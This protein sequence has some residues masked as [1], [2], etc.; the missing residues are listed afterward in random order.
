MLALAVQVGLGQNR[1]LGFYKSTFALIRVACSLLSA[2][3]TFGWW[4]HTFAYAQP[5]QLTI[6]RVVN[7]MHLTVTE[8]ANTYSLFCARPSDYNGSI[9]K[10]INYTK[11]LIKNEKNSLETAFNSIIS[12]LWIWNIRKYFCFI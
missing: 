8:E 5:E 6:L 11:Y 10:S 7:D 9:L 1:T 2:G 3:L 12:D 4:Q